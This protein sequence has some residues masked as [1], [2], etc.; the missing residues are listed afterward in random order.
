VSTG[1]ETGAALAGRRVLVVEDELLVALEVEAAL[2][3]EGCAVLG[4]VPTVDRALAL[5]RGPD[6]P[7]LD[8]A[9]ELDEQ[10][11]EPASS[12]PMW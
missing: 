11:P 9:A 6:A 1:Q 3:P 2:E 7:A 10:E 5:L 8:A 4:P 12:S